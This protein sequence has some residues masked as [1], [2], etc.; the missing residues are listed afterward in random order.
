M[1]AVS[2]GHACA[3][4]EVQRVIAGLGVLPELHIGVIE[5]ICAH[6]HIVEA[7]GGQHHAHIV[8]SIKQ[9]QRLQEKVRIADLQQAEALSA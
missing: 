5:H 7:L 9:W 3:G 1:P 2:N 8:S 6:I 4:D